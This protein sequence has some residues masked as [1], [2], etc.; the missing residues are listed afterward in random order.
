VIADMYEH[1]LLGVH[2]VSG[3][4]Q[5]LIGTGGAGLSLTQLNKPVAVIDHGGLLWAA[6]LDNH[7]IVSLPVGGLN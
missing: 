2:M 5:T 4:T 6:D 1:K 3:E 7:G